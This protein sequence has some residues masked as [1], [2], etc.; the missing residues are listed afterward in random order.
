MKGE[1]TKQEYT[2]RI[3]IVI[4]YIANNLNNNIPLKELSG[5]AN[6]SPFHLQKIFKQVVGE[7]PKQY[8]IKLRLEAALHLLII[9]PYQSI[10]AISADCGFSSPSVFSRAVK[11]YFGI[12]PEAMRIMPFK[13][14]ISVLRNKTPHI[15]LPTIALLKESSLERPDVSIKKISEQRGICLTV[16][17]AGTSPIQTAFRELMAFAEASSLHFDKSKMYG[18]L[19]PHQPQVYKAF[20]ALDDVGHLPSKFKIA[21]IKAGKFAVF[22][23]KGDKEATLNAAH[24]VL[25]KW[26][27]GSGYEIAHLVGFETFLENPA[28]M[29]YNQLQREFYLPVEVE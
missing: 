8:I 19:S 7:T 4:D 20:I 29:P 13:E 3:A 6:Y 10:A 18:I 17:S 25:R 1:A 26:L 28:I 14:K 11:N 22:K 24:V 2:V 21:T 16:S 15:L 23:V 27:A 9:H 12:S 5:L